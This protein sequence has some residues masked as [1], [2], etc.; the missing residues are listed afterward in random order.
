MSHPHPSAESAAENIEYEQF[1]K[2]KAKVLRA[3]ANIKEIMNAFETENKHLK[4]L[5]NQELNRLESH[6][7]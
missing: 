1:L 5:I 7:D 6:F 2:D 4:Y 3:S